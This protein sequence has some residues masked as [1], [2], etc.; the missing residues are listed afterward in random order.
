MEALTDDLA[1]YF[2]N[3]INGETDIRRASDE[4]VQEMYDNGVDIFFNME[5]YL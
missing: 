4:D 2:V 1:I 5:S 3:M